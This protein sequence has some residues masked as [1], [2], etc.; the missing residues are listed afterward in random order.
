MNGNHQSR[1]GR[2][3]DPKPR[4]ERNEGIT[5]AGKQDAIAPRGPELS[6]KLPRGCESH[7]LFQ[8]PRRTDGAGIHAAMTSIDYDQRQLSN[9]NR[10]MGGLDR[11]LAGAGNGLGVP[12]S[13]L[14]GPGGMTMLRPCLPAIRNRKCRRALRRFGERA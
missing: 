7:S 2:D 8:C 3:R 11:R 14:G 1:L 5:V 13:V 6:S 9:V 10:G 12:R 4:G